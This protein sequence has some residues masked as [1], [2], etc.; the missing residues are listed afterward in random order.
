LLKDLVNKDK[1][2]DLASE[3]SSAVT[4]SPKGP[5]SMDPRVWLGMWALRRSIAT[6]RKTIQRTGTSRLAD[7]LG[8]P[9]SRRLAS[10][11]GSTRPLRGDEWRVFAPR[12]PGGRRGPLSLSSLRLGLRLG[13]GGPGSEWSEEPVVG[14]EPAELESVVASCPSGLALRCLRGRSWR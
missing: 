5:T 2:L 9:S 1:T 12:L 6:E 4:T 8:S 10:A 7:G 13:A 11:L 14:V 3:V